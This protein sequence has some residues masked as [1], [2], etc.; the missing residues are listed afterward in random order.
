MLTMLE[1]PPQAMPDAAPAPRI[2]VLDEDAA[3]RR[4]IIDYLRRHGL[5]ADAATADSAS[6]ALSLVVLH[7]RS[8]TQEGLE[9]LRKLRL[10][11]ELQMIAGEWRQA[12]APGLRLRDRFEGWELCRRTRRLTNPAGALVRLTK[13]EYALLCAFLDAPGRPL[14][15]ELLLRATRVHEDIMDRSIDVQV[16][17][18]RR[19]LDAGRASSMIRTERSLGY[20][21]DVAVERA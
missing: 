8:A 12:P 16:L 3:S 2:L 15:R 11:A 13:G 7:L 21:F 10:R 5:Q 17:R 18:L 20:V 19:K 9:A 1:Q 14:S 4:M 6:A